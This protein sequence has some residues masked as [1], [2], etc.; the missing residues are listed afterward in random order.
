MQVNNQHYVIFILDYTLLDL[1]NYNFLYLNQH[2]LDFNL[3]FLYLFYNVQKYDVEIPQAI[4]NPCHIV[5]T[6]KYYYQH[7]P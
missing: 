3:I 5:R 1:F 7:E 2:L 4:G 6:Y